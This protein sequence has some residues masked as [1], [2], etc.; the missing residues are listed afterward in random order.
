MVLQAED[1]PSCPGR[2]HA[3]I[4]LLHCR[5]VATHDAGVGGGGGGGGGGE[6]GCLSAI[7]GGQI[8]WPSSAK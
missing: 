8:R 3:E 1:S 4:C 6:G 2:S 5:A 7:S